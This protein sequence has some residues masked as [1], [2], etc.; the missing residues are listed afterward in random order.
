MTIRNYEYVWAIL[1]FVTTAEHIYNS[2]CPLRTLNLLSAYVKHHAICTFI[3]GTHEMV[4]AL[5]A[6]SQ[7]TQRTILR[8]S[9]PKCHNRINYY[10]LSRF[11][12]SSCAHYFDPCNLHYASSA[13]DERRKKRSL[14]VNHCHERRDWQ[15][16]NSVLGGRTASRTNCIFWRFKLNRCSIGMEWIEYAIASDSLFMLYKTLWTVL[17]IHLCCVVWHVMCIFGM[18]I[19]LNS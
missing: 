16:I 13:T 7:W 11:P 19:E 12:R 17:W 14:L 3:I 4:N 10:P 5:R 15:L 6:G 2:H 18:L 9:A 1:L 8:L